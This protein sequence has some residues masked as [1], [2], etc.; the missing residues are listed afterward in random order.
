MAPDPPR[1]NSRNDS[2]LYHSLNMKAT[3]AAMVPSAGRP[4]RRK[5]RRSSQLRRNSS[6][7]TPSTAAEKGPARRAAA[8]PEATTSPR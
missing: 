6:F 3:S 7:T 4:E 1:G 2:G 8:G 5:Q